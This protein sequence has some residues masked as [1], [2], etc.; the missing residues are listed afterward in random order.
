[1]LDRVPF[2]NGFSRIETGFENVL[3]RQSLS[4]VLLFLFLRRRSFFRLSF[5]VAAFA[6]VPTERKTNGTH[7]SVLGHTVPIAHR[8][9]QFYV[10]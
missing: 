1:M 7:R 9:L 3:L 2:S 10:L 5:G 8:H 6:R 4:G